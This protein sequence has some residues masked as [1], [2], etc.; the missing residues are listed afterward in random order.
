MATNRGREPPDLKPEE[1]GNLAGCSPSK[2]ASRPPIAPVI[3]PGP[4]P[5]LGEQFGSLTKQLHEIL[6]ATRMVVGDVQRVRSQFERERVATVDAVSTVS[7][8]TAAETLDQED[9]ADD[10]SSDSGVRAENMD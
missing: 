3:P 7:A 9:P 5:D 10:T 8:V 6:S 4:S 1:S 2:M